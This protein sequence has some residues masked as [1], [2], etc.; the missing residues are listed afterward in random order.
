M[1][2][3]LV[4][5]NPDNRAWERRL[6]NF[7]HLA[8]QT[9]LNLGQIG[10]AEQHINESV[11]RLSKLVRFEPDNRVWQRD[12]AHALMQS[13]D[14]LAYSHSKGDSLAKLR[15]AQQLTASLVSSTEVQPEWRRLDALLRTRIAA[16]ESNAEMMDAAVA[17]LFRLPETSPDDTAGRPALAQALVLRGRMRLSTGYPDLAREDGAHAID[18]LNPVLL[19]NIRDPNALAPFVSAHALAGNLKAIE[20][21]IDYLRRIGYRHPDFEQPTEA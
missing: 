1:L 11:S 10:D 19:R 18:I 4:E 5:T 21:Q 14:I 20:V 8:S 9:K 3:K 7:L 2:R 17:D 12:Y 16:R 13:A 6:T 15:V